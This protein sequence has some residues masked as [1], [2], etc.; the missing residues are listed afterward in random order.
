MTEQ[1]GQ[2]TL[3]FGRYAS[4]LAAITAVIYVAFALLSYQQY[5][6]TRGRLHDSERLSARAELNNS[7]H[8]VLRDLRAGV[9]D[10]SDW[11]ELFQ[12]LANPRYFAYWHSHRIAQSGV[13][14]ER[15]DELMLYDER[16]RALTVL[17]DNPLPESVTPG[18][19]RESYH[20]EGG[21][22]RVVFIVPLTRDPGT[23]VVGYLGVN[24]RLLPSIRRLHA[25]NLIDIQSLKFVGGTLE[26]VGDIVDHARYRLVQTR[27]FKL[28]DGLV[29]DTIIILGALVVLPSLLLMIVSMRVVGH[30]VRRVPAVIERLRSSGGMEPVEDGPGRGHLPRL[31]L[32]ELHAAEQSLIDYHHE[33]SE[34]N[35]V[36]DEKN[37]ELWVMAHQDVLTRAQ[38]RRAFDEF[39]S[40]LARGRG[41]ASDSVRLMLCDINHFKAI[42]DSYGH[43]V[44]DLV[45]VAVANCLRNALG[46]GQ[47]LFRLGGDEFACVLRNCTKPQAMAVAKRC[48]EAVKHH[49][50]ADELD[51][52]EPVRLSI[53]V[54]A[55]EAPRDVSVTELMRQA[56]MAMYASKRPGQPTISVY[57]HGMA[58]STSGVFSIGANEAVYQAL[59]FGH[60]IVMYYQPV[61]DLRTNAA[62]YYEALVRLR[63]G[64]RLFPPEE[65][66]PVVEARH[67]EME[68][69]R[70]IIGQ[71][72]RDLEAGRLPQGAGVAVNLSGPSVVNEQVVEWLRP[73]LAFMDAMKLVIEV[74]ETSLITQMEA[75]TENLEHLRSL[76]FEVALDD[77]GSGY[78]SLR[79]LTSMPVD[80]VK[81]DLTLI[82]ALDDPEQRVL[83]EHLASLISGNGH[84]LVAEGI[85]DRRML[86]KVMQVGFD[87]VQGHWLGR[88]DPHPGGAPDSG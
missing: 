2:R 57:E 21:D 45:L 7:V 20:V 62:A 41:P 24:A 12:Q 9:Q 11:D 74:T 31:R 34:A 23:G 50:F 25:F 17:S 32:E 36:L 79:Y 4:W 44:G 82:Q 1:K 26:S 60:G 80:I 75:A 40:E 38:N 65:F 37:R 52:V 58:S 84:K 3:S 49:P 8:K 76:G 10:L 69:D 47:P 33:L 68:M 71:V 54:S 70:V 13:L 61:V 19:A 35:R 22:L 14:G 81:F 29:V 46:P 59:D 78:S 55:P 85:E 86:E 87:F 27:S 6:S 43:P 28:I 18:T 67:L 30:A 56:D 5:Q 16:G 64:D 15:F 66:M 63:L 53:G 88:P 73:L 42:N 77:F 72:A 39:W 51:L 48:E 83:V